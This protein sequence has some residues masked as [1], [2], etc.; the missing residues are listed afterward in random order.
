MPSKTLVT[1]LV[2]LIALGPSVAAGGGRRHELDV[3]VRGSGGYE[4]DADGIATLDGLVEAGRPIPAIEGG[5]IPDGRA[6]D[7]GPRSGTYDG[8]LRPDDSSWPRAHTCEPARAELVVHGR[9]AAQV[10][11]AAAG[12]LCGPEA[13]PLTPAL[14]G[15]FTGH[16]EGADL[17]VRL[18]ASGTAFVLVTGSVG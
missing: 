4:L 11:V 17:T 7:G 3:D 14:T 13:V 9:D 6:G 8:S 5:V 15:V 1:M 16:V 10:T 12:E 2:G 18:T